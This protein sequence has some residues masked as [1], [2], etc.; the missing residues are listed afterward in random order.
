MSSRDD[1]AQFGRDM[2][3][4]KRRSRGQPDD[5]AAVMR[6]GVALMIIAIVLCAI[7]LVGR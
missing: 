6:A 5:S 4:A 2:R 7:A 3:R 1:L